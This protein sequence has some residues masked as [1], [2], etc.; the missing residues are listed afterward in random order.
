MPRKDRAVD[1]TTTTSTIYDKEE[2]LLASTKKATTQ[3]RTMNTSS[4][5]ACLTYKKNQDQDQL[6]STK[7]QIDEAKEENQRLKGMLSKIMKD[8]KSLKMHF[9]G[10]ITHENSKDIIATTSSTPNNIEEEE[11]QQVELVSLRLG[12]SSTT[13]TTTSREL[14][15]FDEYS[16]KSSNKKHSKLF[17]GLELG[18]D[19]KFTCDHSPENSF[20]ESKKENINE[21]FVQNYPPSKLMDYDN[22]DHE[23]FLQHIPQ[24]KARV[25]IRAVCGTATMN[26]GC[27]WRKYGQKI[28]KGNPCSNLK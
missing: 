18:L 26:D 13:T 6:N 24:K 1:S 21:P 15:E 16:C 9:H 23:D 22:D 5:D 27:Q 8:Y 2:E 12:R 11:E 4:R 25:S 10:I 20:E 3:K 28:A 7:C 19:C 14:K 17:D